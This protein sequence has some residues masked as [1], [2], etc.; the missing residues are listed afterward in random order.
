[1][2][3]AIAASRPFG[4][5]PALPPEVTG[6]P[7]RVTADVDS[8]DTC[9]VFDVFATDAPGLMFALASAVAEQGL[10]VRLAKISTHLDQ[11]VDVFYVTDADGAK[12]TD[13]GRLE[14]IREALLAR[15]RAF[16]A[17]AQR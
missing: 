17:D 14:T 4:A 1:M 15:V 13:P 12:V 6:E 10:T 9:T 2:P 16:E 5:A 7:V 8:S 11:V 3:A